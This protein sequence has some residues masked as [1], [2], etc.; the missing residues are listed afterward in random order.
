MRWLSATSPLV[1]RGVV[2]GR[3]RTACLGAF[4][5]SLAVRSTQRGLFP[6]FGGTVD[7]VRSAMD[8]LVA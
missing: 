7:D 3:R 1:G 8:L 2:L 4:E 5:W 6:V